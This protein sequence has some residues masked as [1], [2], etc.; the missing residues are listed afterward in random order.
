M[1]GGCII[2]FNLIMC[3]ISLVYHIGVYKVLLL[4]VERDN[5]CIGKTLI[6]GLV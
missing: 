5:Y 1:L 2:N 6:Q 3:D 4:G